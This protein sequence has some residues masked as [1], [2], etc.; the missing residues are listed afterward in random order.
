MQVSGLTPLLEERRRH[1][2]DPKKIYK[3]SNGNSESYEVLI[4]GCW[5]NDIHEEA[6]VVSQEERMN[7]NGNGDQDDNKSSSPLKKFA[8]FAFAQQIL[9]M[10]PYLEKGGT[11]V[12]YAH[13]FPDLKTLSLMWHLLRL[14][15]CGNVR[16]KKT[17]THS[18]GCF[19]VCQ[20]FPGA[21]SKLCTD[22]L[23]ILLAIVER[24]SGQSNLNPSL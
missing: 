17:T 6:E 4:L 11:L 21:E 16:V 19:F 1:E 8:N 20:D 7:D 23:E 5:L 2:D 13:S 14:F 10:L 24:G 9:E 15:G 3:A 12:L 22:F 18:S